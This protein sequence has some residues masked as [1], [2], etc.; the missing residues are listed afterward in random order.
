[1]YTLQIMIMFQKLLW[2]FSTGGTSLARGLFKHLFTVEELQTH[3][4]NGR[5][6]P[7]LGEDQV[8][9]PPLDANRKNA[10]FSKFIFL[11]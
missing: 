1:M 4:L 11:S 5:K 6:C 7:A 2:F 8:I 9:R 10:I 3:S